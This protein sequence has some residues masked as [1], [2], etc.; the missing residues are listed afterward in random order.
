[1]VWTHQ[2]YWQDSG[3]PLAYFG[4]LFAA[5]NLIFGFAGRAAAL[6]S[7]RYGRRTLLPRSVS[8]P[9]SRA[10]DGVARGLGGICSEPR[11]GRSGP[12]LRVFLNTL[13]EKLSSAFRA[14][15]IS[16]AQLG[17]RAAFALVGPLVGYGIDAW[18]LSSVLSALGVSVRGR[19][20][21]AAAAA[22]AAR[23][24]A[25]PGCC[26]E[27][28]THAVSRSRA[29]TSGA[30]GAAPPQLVLVVAAPPD[31][32]SRCGPGGAVE[33]LVHAPEPSTP[34]A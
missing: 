7:A 26:V 30:P 29:V 21:V 3:L 20:R 9:S 5:Y 28:L 1:M 23:N 13:N 10:W 4:V 32:P 11:P 27:R 18:G 19:L 31:A 33:P 17:T 15:V 24:A 12:G 8:C 6:A 14:T 34:R 22:G 2:K 25:G 16:M